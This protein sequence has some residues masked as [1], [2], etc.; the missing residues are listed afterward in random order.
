[1]NQDV[2]VKDLIIIGAGPAGMSAAIYACRAGIDV[3]VLEKFSPGG[4]VINTY[5]VENYPGFK[6]VVS[7]FELVNAMEEQ[8]KK[9]GMIT[10]N[11]D[12]SSFKRE[13]DGT[14]TVKGSGNESF[15][16]RALI[17]A[18]GSNY[19]KLGVPGEAEF[20]GS[21]VS[22]CATCDGAFYRDKVTAVI[23]GGNT[24]L[25]EALFLTRF[26]SKVYI[27][28]RRGEFRGEKVIQ[29]RIDANPKIVKIM[30]SVVE[31]V[32][33]TGRV[34]SMTVKNNK[35]GETKEYP[36]DGFF[37][38]VGFDPCTKFVPK[39]LCDEWGQIKT[40]MRMRTAV[41]GLYAAG[42]IRIE[43]CKQI[44]TACADGATAALCAY[45]YLNR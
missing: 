12:V 14:F 15:R 38:F 31:K 17:L 35:S 1:M 20:L 19:K 23:G 18:M 29:D 45:E 2:K 32:N 16:S 7:G 22:Y 11:V 30:D 36:I 9:F 10:E 42:D 5:E 3:L 44:I 34:Q 25:E 40:D 27:V 6:E 4:Q 39:E 13:E 28:H 33:G 24:A 41:P 21:G 43:S 8:A 37:V 26:A